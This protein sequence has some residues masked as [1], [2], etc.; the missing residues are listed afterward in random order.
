MTRNL[1]PWF[2]RAARLPDFETEFPK[3]M[4]EVFGPD[5]GFLTRDGK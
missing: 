5:A 2:T 4:T 3:W 1:T